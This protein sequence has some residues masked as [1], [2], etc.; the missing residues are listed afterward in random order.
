MN[1]WVKKIWR[2]YHQIILYVY[3]GALTFLVDT[4]V[5]F[6]LSHIFPTEENAWILHG[7]SIFSTLAAITFA[8]I[9]N[10][11][12]VF[13]SKIKKGKALLREIVEFYSARCLTMIVAEVLLNFFVLNMDVS[14]PLAKLLVNVLVIVLNY[15]FSKFWIFKKRKKKV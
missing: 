14:A 11:K 3:F 4:G 6:V 13:R 5:F 10:R 8:Y 2:R 15:I 12:Y 9:T 7:C 1:G